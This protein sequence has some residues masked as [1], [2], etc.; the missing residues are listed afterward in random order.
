MSYARFWPR[1]WPG[2]LEAF[3]HFEGDIPEDTIELMKNSYYFE[4]IQFPV[5][6]N[7]TGI[8]WVDAWDNDGR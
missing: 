5:H 1:H 8:L 3:Y 2:G 4:L 7:V 6:H